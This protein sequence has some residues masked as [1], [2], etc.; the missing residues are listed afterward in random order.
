MG[1]GWR[2]NSN[3]PLSIRVYVRNL[4]EQL[5]PYKRY[6]F[7]TAWP[8]FRIF[9]LLTTA[10]CL[11]SVTPIKGPGSLQPHLYLQ[12]QYTAKNSVTEFSQ[13]FLSSKPKACIRQFY[14]NSPKF[15]WLKYLEKKKWTVNTSKLHEKVFLNNKSS[16]HSCDKSY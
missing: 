6:I 9:A 4:S 7:F 1:G 12:G 16:F 11:P 5:R 15:E 14:E 8:G 10:H 3:H 2:L 13:D